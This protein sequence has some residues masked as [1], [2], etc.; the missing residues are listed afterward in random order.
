MSLDVS[1]KKALSDIRM[2]KAL[3]FLKDAHANLG[4]AVLW[5]SG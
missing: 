1:D 4:G 2:E 3:E 5:G